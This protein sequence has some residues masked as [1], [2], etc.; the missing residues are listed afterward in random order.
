MDLF[1]TLRDLES[2]AHVANLDPATKGPLNALFYLCPKMS[3]KGLQVNSS[4]T[5]FTVRY[6]E[7]LS[8]STI[9]RLQRAERFVAQATAVG[10]EVSLTAIFAAADAEML[11]PIPVEPPPVPEIPG[12]KVISNLNVFKYSLDD[13]WEFYN[14]VP[15]RNVPG[16]FV[17]QEV[18]RLTALLPTDCSAKVREVF[19]RTPWVDRNLAEAFIRRILAGFALD[20]LLLS[21]GYFGRQAVLL[22]VESPGVA[23]LQNAALPREQRIPVIQLH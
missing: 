22:G 14:R 11:F 7:G 3:G 12:L 16:R 2:V 18:R 10:V 6:V 1:A 4:K 20:G 5:G 21:R 23:V 19:I 17:E 13:F 9:D 8:E 15:W